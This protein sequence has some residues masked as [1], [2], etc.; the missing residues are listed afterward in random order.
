[1]AGCHG[2]RDPLIPSAPTRE[3]RDEG[4]SPCRRE[5]DRLRE[6]CGE[7]VDV[8]HRETGRAEGPRHPGVVADVREKGPPPEP[9]G[10]DDVHGRRVQHGPPVEHVTDVEH[11]RIRRRGDTEP[12]AQQAA[13]PPGGTEGGRRDRDDGDRCPS[14]PEPPPTPASAVA[15]PTAASTRTLVPSAGAPRSAVTSRVVRPSWNASRRSCSTTRRGRDGS[16]RLVPSCPA[17]SVVSTT[18]ARDRGASRRCCLDDDTDRRARRDAAR[19]GGE[20]T[21]G[22]EQASVGHAPHLERGVLITGEHQTQGDHP[23]EDGRAPH[24]RREGEPASDQI[25]GADG[26][27]HLRHRH[28]CG[29]ADHGELPEHHTGQE[30]LAQTHAVEQRAG[31]FGLLRRRIFDAIERV[32][33]RRGHGAEE[34]FIGGPQL[35]L[36]PL[37]AGLRQRDREETPAG[38][39]P[40]LT[41]IDGGDV[42]PGQGLFA[43]M[44]ATRRDI[45]MSRGE[46]NA[47]ERP[48]PHRLD[49]E[50]GD[51][52]PSASQAQAP[53]QTSG[54]NR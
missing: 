17:E 54:P 13:E 15:T 27:Q 38:E 25:V 16:T 53:G 41:R 33:G 45:Q 36:R 51:E 37:V 52:G 35:H 6:P 11:D 1:M 14:P 44:D 30:Q 47:R 9:G 22:D 48:P 28:R 29:T 43:A 4:P 42:G 21:V 3:T 40:R 20:Q 2:S 31:R 26:L 49:D 19:V 46:L 50:D 12:R 18:T 7:S 39:G 24:R 5:R 32:P 10:R 8:V 34:V 23:A